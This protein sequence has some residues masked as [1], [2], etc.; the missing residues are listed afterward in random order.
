MYIW[1]IHIY[2]YLTETTTNGVHKTDVNDKNFTNKE[3]ICYDN[4][5]NSFKEVWKWR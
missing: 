3:F 4:H 5:K 2:S 1:N